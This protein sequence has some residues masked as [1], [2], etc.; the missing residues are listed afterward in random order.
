MDED[1]PDLTWPMIGEFVVLL[2]IVLGSATVH[3]LVMP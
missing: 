1:N 2:I 3:A